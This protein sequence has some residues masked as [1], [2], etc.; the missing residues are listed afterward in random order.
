[1]HEIL[2]LQWD[3]IFKGAHYTP[4]GCPLHPVCFED[5][6]IDTFQKI[7]HSSKHLNLFSMKLFGHH[8]RIVL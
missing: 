5:D 3:H 8:Y 2:Y 6:E 4:G 1:M 7:D